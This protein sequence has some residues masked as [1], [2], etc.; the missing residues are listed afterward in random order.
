[1]ISTIAEGSITMPMTSSMMLTTIRNS[2][3]PSPSP[4]IQLVID[5]GIC[6]EVRMK[7]N[8]AALVMM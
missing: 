1:M 3:L 5:W 7:A 6:S 2:I 4:V 8:I